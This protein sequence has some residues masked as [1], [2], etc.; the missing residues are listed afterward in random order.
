MNRRKAERWLS[1][2]LDGELDARRSALLERWLADEPALR[3]RAETWK[4]EGEQ[5]RTLAGE[6]PDAATGWADV[7]TALARARTDG[8]EQETT[9]AF[10][11]RWSWS[12]AMVVLLLAAVGLGLWSQR[13]GVKVVASEAAEPL[14]VEWAET[15]LPGASTM[16]FRD[17]ETG[18][19]VIWLVEDGDAENGHAGS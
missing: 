15:E 8:A 18:L 12:T 9:T 7:R 4:A 3:A 11:S 6:V 19:T 1:R 10:G 16:V 17:E 5:L 2:H 13:R 14:E